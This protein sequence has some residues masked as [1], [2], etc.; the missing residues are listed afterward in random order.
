M[1]RRNVAVASAAAALL[2]LGLTKGRKRLQ[3][4]RAKHPGIVG[5]ARMGKRVAGAD[6]L[7]DYD[8]QRFFA[9]D[10]CLPLPGRAAPCRASTGCRRRFRARFAKTIAQT[11]RTARAFPSCSSPASTVCRSIQPGSP[12]AA[13]VGVFVQSSKGVKVTDLDGNDFYDLTGSYGVNLFGYDFYKETIAQGSA[14]AAE[15]A[16]ASGCSTR[17]SPTMSNG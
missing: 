16:R 7:Y 13:P 14:M 5:H 1:K 6:P 3:L 8:E 17:S 9:A 4:S 12:R 11:K 2:T 10:E 15:L